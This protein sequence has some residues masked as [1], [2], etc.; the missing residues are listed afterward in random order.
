MIRK[1]LLFVVLTS[2][3]AI[4]AQEVGDVQ[5]AIP[6]LIKF[7]GSLQTKGSPH[8]VGVTFALYQEETG[9]ASLWIE[10]ENVM[11]DAAGRFTVLLGSATTGGLPSSLFL[12]GDARWLGVAPENEEERPRIMLASVPY[13]F[14]AADAQTIGGLTPG[15][16][17]TQKQFA[18]YLGQSLPSNADSS[19]V[20]GPRRGTQGEMVVESTQFSGNGEAASNYGSTP[21]APLGSHKFTAPATRSSK[22]RNALNTQAVESGYSWSVGNIPVALTAGTQATVMITPCPEG[23]DTSGSPNLGGPNGGYPVYIADAASPANSE[24]VPVTDGTC[25]SG[26]SSGT[27]VFT[28]YSSHA[29]S[30]YTIGSS[31]SGIQETINVACGAYVTAVLNGGCQVVIPPTGPGNVTG[32]DVY[33]TIYFHANASALSGYGVTL[34]C[35]GRGPCLQVGDLLSSNDY[36][37]NTVEGISFRI[38][39]NHQ[40]DPA[41]SG[42]LITSTQTTS[43]TITIQTAAPHNLRTGDRVTQML[44]DTS[45]YWGDVPSISVTDATHYSYP[46]PGTTSLPLQ[47]TPGIVALT[48]VAVLDN[49]ASTSLTD[50]EFSRTN[51][52]GPF[53]HFFDLWDDENAQINGF[54]NNG[55][56][57]NRNA[58]WTGSFV[59]SG[60]ASNLPNVNQQLAPVITVKNASITANG[61]NCATV[62]NSND[63]S[64]ENSICEA[65]SLWQFLISDVTGNYQGANFQNIYSESSLVLNPSSPAKSPWPGLGIAGFIGGPISGAGTFSLSGQGQ[66]SGAMPTVGTGPTTYVYL[67]VARD[68]TAGTQTSPLPFMYEQESSPGQVKIP[69]PRLSRGMDVIVYD[70]I[71]NPAP[72]GSIGDV[73]GGY[74]AP[75]TG[76]CNGGSPSACGYIAIGLPQC[77]GFVCTFT[78]N[79]ANNTS[80]YNVANGT[81]Q[82]NPTFWPGAAVLSAAP[83]QSSSNEV[84]AIGVAFNGAPLE[85]ANYCNDDDLNVS[86]GYTVC[87]GT[88]TTPNN[89]VPDQPPLILTDGLTTGDGGVP[90]AKG[91]LIFDHLA[92]TQLIWHQVITVYDSNP[93]KTMATTTHRPVGDPGDIYLGIDPNSNLM[94]GGGVNGIA[95]YVNNIGNGTPGELLTSLGKFF[96][97]PVQAP[98]INV[99]QLLL[100]G[101]PGQPGQ[102]PIATATGTVWGTCG[103]ATSSSALALPGGGPPPIER[104]EPPI[105]FALAAVR[106]QVGGDASTNSGLSGDASLSYGALANGACESQTFALN[107]VRAGEAVIAKWPVIFEG[108][109]LGDMRASADS[110]IEVRVCNLSGKMLTPAPHIYGAL[111]PP[112]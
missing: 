103:N 85:Y 80:S 6:L 36:S 23:V 19:I 49:A 11:V 105:N 3:A 48:Y 57:L 79:T 95:Q 41:F 45:S 44:T 29:P 65:Q 17:V 4:G 20:P 24:S 82:P 63:F 58:N 30:T 99:T 96:T 52:E 66:F 28:P 107:G 39:D 51:Q 32:Y 43:G 108:G 5:N 37:I 106:Q 2:T 62:Y 14:K 102:V 35:H 74:V 61:S 110:T 100:N 83:L 50:I 75:Y 10:T 33:D 109:L 21:G 15:E 88:I 55:G 68:L 54:S 40:S 12:S 111:I 73:A 67:A 91:R 70:L 60:G 69:W 94:I 34:N 25:T 9:G 71:R 59:W 72:G 86:G 98:N 8:I 90:G 13:A 81:F 84:P 22:A 42:S 78:D 1:F 76:G 7:V 31:S 27:L 89:A 101:V 104:I 47:I 93:L 77:S 92:N 26:A 38:P 87:A 16:F 18:S 64:F 112:H 53:N 97:V 46:R 56:S